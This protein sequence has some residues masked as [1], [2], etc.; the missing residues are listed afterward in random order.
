MEISFKLY[1]NNPKDSLYAS[2]LW[3]L[4]EDELF[5]RLENYI[6]VIV[7]FY[8][9]NFLRICR[10]EKLHDHPQVKNYYET[11]KRFRSN[12]KVNELTLLPWKKL[13]DMDALDL[14]PRYEPITN[15]RKKEVIQ[16]IALLLQIHRS[17]ELLNKDIL[18]S[19]T[20]ITE[21]EVDKAQDMMIKFLNILN[22]YKE[23]YGAM[24]DL[25]KFINDNITSPVPISII[26][27]TS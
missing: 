7:C 13:K 3:L 27:M 1:L 15:K 10:K 17:I 24:F 2:I 8:P 12:R 14:I 4:L 19:N 23:S 6:S 11:A 21:N 18:W 22:I 5:R 26:Q 20:T 9:E 25:K 16:K